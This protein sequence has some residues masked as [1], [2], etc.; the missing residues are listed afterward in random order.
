MEVVVI[1]VLVVGAMQVVLLVSDQSLEV[2]VGQF[3]HDREP[4][5]LQEFFVDSGGS[6][7]DAQ[8]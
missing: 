4:N 7:Q 8:I 3:V 1:G 2:K 5:V 6:A